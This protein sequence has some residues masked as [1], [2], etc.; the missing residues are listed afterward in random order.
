M[1]V[2]EK[3]L[4]WLICVVPGLTWQVMQFTLLHRGHL[5]MLTSSSNIVHPAQSGV[6]QWKVFFIFASASFI[7]FL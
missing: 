7:D 1:I 3:K 4:G 6:L 5:K 2:T